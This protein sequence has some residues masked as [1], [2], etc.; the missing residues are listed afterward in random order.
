MTTNSPRNSPAPTT[1]WTPEHEQK[2]RLGLLLWILHVD[3][4][5]DSVVCSA[6]PAAD[7]GPRGRLVA[8][9][10]DHPQREADKELS[11]VVHGTVSVGGLGEQP[12]EALLLRGEVDT[13]EIRHACVRPLVV[14]S[15]TSLNIT[16]NTHL[17]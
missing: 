9:A 16:F 10:P 3:L 5:G 4:G 14:G 2:P 15:K 13:C 6:A 17:W 7:P 12:G 11:T 8:P 1:A